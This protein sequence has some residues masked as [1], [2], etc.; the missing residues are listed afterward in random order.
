M[1]DV[2]LSYSRTNEAFA[3]RLEAAL[4]AAEP[5]QT[6][7][8]DKSGLGPGVK[9][10][11]EVQQAIATSHNFV[12]VITPE[13]VR[14][15]IAG[16]RVELRPCGFE[17][18]YAVSLGKRIVPVMLEYTPSATLHP[19]VRECNYIDFRDAASF[20]ESLQKLLIAL[21][22]DV[23]WVH[24]H[25]RLQNRAND[26]QTQHRDRSYLLLGKDLT[27]AERWMVEPDDT[28]A[29]LRPTPLQVE[30]IAE[31]RAAA[32]RSQRRRTGIAYTL[33][34]AMLCLTAYSVYQQYAAQRAT[35]HLAAEVVQFSWVDIA[36]QQEEK[37]ALRAAAKRLNVS[38]YD[39][40]PHDAA[41]YIASDNQSCSTY[42]TDGFRYLYCSLRDVIGLARLQSISG[43][44]VFLPGGPHGDQLNLNSTRGFGHYNPE[45]LS[46]LERNMIPAP[47]ADAQTNDLIRLA[48]QSQLGP[49]ARA[50]Y[51]THAILFASPQ[52][53]VAFRKVY[54]AAKASYI[55]GGGREG[56]YEYAGDVQPSL[57]TAQRA[58][59]RSI[60]AGA[61]LDL[62]E[63]Y[64]WLSDY[65][66]YRDQDDWYLANTAGGFW[67]RRSL[68]GTEPQVFR[69]VTKLLKTYDAAW[70]AAA[71]ARIPG[72][73]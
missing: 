45:F 8:R 63:T 47:G 29:G 3:A 1:A 32:T 71:Q 61:P 5:P 11:P 46:W 73:H 35:R 17:I 2:F 31:S 50:L 27:A 59:T 6:V 51:D 62:G 56:Y 19:A 68:D 7:W 16:P 42:L 9:W 23:E 60:A 10:R 12:F 25:T 30:Y 37:E 13:S 18:D 39:L 41:G 14:D 28:H 40:L 21:H 36:H 64:R 4:E 72:A 53:A 22:T 70:L 65:T 33:V 55:Q 26:W 20:D 44:K 49:A 34:A 54:E 58:Y 43:K 69:I 24:A 48:Y 52:G 67:L 66:A 38:T 15:T 57:E